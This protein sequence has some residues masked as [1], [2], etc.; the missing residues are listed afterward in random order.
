MYTYSIYI[1]V[2]TLLIQSERVGMICGLG[3]LKKVFVFLCLSALHHRA[4]YNLFDCEPK[5]KQ[6]LINEER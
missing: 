6:N 1:Q 5:S 4:S 3:T 2:L